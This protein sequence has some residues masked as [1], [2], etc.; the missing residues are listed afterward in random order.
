[1]Q[2]LDMPLKLFRKFYEL[3]YSNASRD[4]TGIESAVTQQFIHYFF[5]VLSNRLFIVY[6][7]I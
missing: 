6:I 1:M 2:N 5:I 4:Y 3:S 7:M